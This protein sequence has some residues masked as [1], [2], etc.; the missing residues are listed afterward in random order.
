VVDGSIP[1]GSGAQQELREG[2]WRNPASYFHY[3]LQWSVIS[4]EAFFHKTMIYII[5]EAG[6]ALDKIIFSALQCGFF[7]A[8]KTFS[9]KI[10]PCKNTTG[11]SHLL[12]SQQRIVVY[13]SYQLNYI[14]AHVLGIIELPRFYSNF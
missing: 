4:A 9:Y 3:Y 14:K 7:N 6:L 13:I 12:N 5:P 11:L 10:M 2:R 1:D 8:A